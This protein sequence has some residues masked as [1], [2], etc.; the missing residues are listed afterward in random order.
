MRSV[1]SPEPVYFNVPLVVVLPMAIVPF[2]AVVGAP[3]AL[4]ADAGPVAFGV[5][6]T[7]SHFPSGYEAI[8]YGRGT[9]LLHMLRHMMRDAERN[10][11]GHSANISDAQA[12]EPFFRALGKV[13]DRFQ[14]KSITTRE[15]L[16]VFEE[17]LPPSLWF[18]Q[19]KSLDWFYQSWVNGT[20]IPRLELKSVKYGE[21]QGGAIV[22]GT[23]S[24][25]EA[26]RE[27]VTA[28]PVYAVLGKKTVLLGR[29]FAEGPET[30][31][32]LS[33]PT[34]TRKVVLDPYQTLL[35]RLR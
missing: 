17:E 3:I 4:L 7:S 22:T 29:V 26:P 25:S 28:V 27:Q 18:E 35:T 20:A 8:T 14:E 6:L 23:I 15:L 24:Q 31:F 2:N 9:W 16:H 19:R 30:T 11:S 13:R 12:D 5:R 33:A 34:G 32:H 1:V 10:S 21:K